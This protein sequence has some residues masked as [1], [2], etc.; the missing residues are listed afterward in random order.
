MGVPVKAQ[1]SDRFFMPFISNICAH[2]IQ[3]GK[4]DDPS[5][6]GP[7]ARAAYKVALDLDRAAEAR[8]DKPEAG[9]PGV[10]QDVPFAPIGRGISG[11]CI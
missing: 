8:A 5:K 3:V 6:I 4:I 11:H 2:A 1:A 7:W 10:D 9:I